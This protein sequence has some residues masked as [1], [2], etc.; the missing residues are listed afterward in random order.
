M[1]FQI[2]QKVKCIEPDDTTLRMGRTYTVKR[3]SYTGGLVKVTNADD[4]NVAVIFNSLLND[5]WFCVERFIALPSD[6][7]YDAIDDLPVEAT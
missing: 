7:P 5:D 2:G 1:R 4:H 6:N 3:V